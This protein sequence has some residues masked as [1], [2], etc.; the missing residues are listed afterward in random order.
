GRSFDLNAVRRAIGIQVHAVLQCRV[1]TYFR[2]GRGAVDH[3][4][5][6]ASAHLGG[7]ATITT[8]A[9]GLVAVCCTTGT[10]G[11][12]LTHGTAEC[13]FLGLALGIGTGFGGGLGTGFTFRV[14]FGFSF[15]IRLGFGFCIGFGLAFGIGLGFR[16]G[17][18]FSLALCVCLG[19]GFS[20]SFF[21][22]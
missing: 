5:L 6:H 16:V 15:G 1:A 10:S 14:C 18:C 13:F 11:G 22:A 4:R 20:F 9:T 3:A 17:F 8:T 19:F 21:L 2:A 7:I 12:A